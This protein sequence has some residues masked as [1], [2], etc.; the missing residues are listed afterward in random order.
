MSL[1]SNQPSNQSTKPTDLLP[2]E[3]AQMLRELERLGAEEA[4]AAA[5]KRGRAQVGWLGA[6]PVVV[7]CLGV[8]FGSVLYPH[9]IGSRVGPQQ[10]W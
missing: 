2:Q 7:L 5:D 3:R 8:S 9:N 10:M 4:K 1:H 6:C